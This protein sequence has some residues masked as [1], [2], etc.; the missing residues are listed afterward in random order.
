V[1][2]YE[3]SPAAIRA[4]GIEPNGH[5]FKRGRGCPRCNH[6]GYLGRVGLFE[7]LGIDEMVQDMIMARTSAREITRAA[8]KAGTL[9]TLRDDAAA[10]VLAGETTLEEAASA[11]LV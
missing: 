5:E 9:R 10:K 6:V 8:V 1:E 3:P 4:M 11:V 2:T 7:V